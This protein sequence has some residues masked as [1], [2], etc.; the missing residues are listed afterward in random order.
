M[1]GDNRFCSDCLSLL[2]RISEPLCPDCGGPLNSIFACCLSCA[3]QPVRPWS[4]AVAIFRHQEP[5]KNLIHQ[6]KY[7]QR[8]DI[9]RAF[10]LV[11]VDEISRLSESPDLIVAVPLHW[12]R[13][14]RRGYNQAAVFGEVLARYTGIPYGS[15]LRRHYSNGHQMEKEKSRRL[16]MMTDLFRCRDGVDLVGKH[17]LL[18]DDVMTTGATLSAAA[19]ALLDGGARRVSVLV[20]SRR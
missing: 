14:L 18:V 13:Y 17:I 10:A 2:P 8:P 3:G 11:A 16:K 5:V 9:A 15:P 1:V 6:L 12:M 20:I 4:Q 7:R 19:H